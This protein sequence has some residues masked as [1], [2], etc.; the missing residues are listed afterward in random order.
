MNTCKAILFLTIFLLGGCAQS[1]LDIFPELEDPSLMDRKISVTELH[2]DI[3]AFVAGVQARH[4][5]F[6]GYANQQELQQSVLK[7]KQ[8]IDQ[9]LT[10]VEFFRYVGQLSHLFNDGHSFLIWPYQEYAA[11]VDAGTAPFP[12]A[13]KEQDGSLYLARD[14]NLSTDSES[15]TLVAGSRI[16][17]INGVS[18]EQIIEQGQHFVGGET[19]RLREAF[20]AARF[21]YILWA[22]FGMIGNFEL[23]VQHET[24]VDSI[25]L[26]STQQWQSQT[27]QVAHS[28]LELQILEPGLGY[29]R[30]SSFDVDPE[31]FADDIAEYFSTIKQQNIQHLIIDIRDNTGGNT[32]TATELASYLADKPFQ[33]VSHVTERLNEDNRGWFGY[34]GS[35][36]D[37]I[38]TPWTDEV[39]PKSEARRFTGNVYVLIGPVTYSAAIVFATTVQDNEMGTLVGESTGGYANQTAQGNLFNLPHSQ[40]RAYVATRL[41]VRPNG[42][43]EVTTVVPDVIVQP[44]VASG[45]DTALTKIKELLQ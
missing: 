11:A 17:S 23:E 8:H 27:A 14:Y 38:R 2:Q 29:L 36:G 28:E 3:D 15:K 37:I 45:S 5:D 18:A 19:Q 1:H 41:L 13:V 35:V 31:Q 40:L 22:V 21:P 6:D 4:P 34:K 33:L 26:N 44:D 32:D 20:V 9:P 10:R 30:V 43:R 16:I 39:N 42:A 7:L 24:Q 25:K 12:F